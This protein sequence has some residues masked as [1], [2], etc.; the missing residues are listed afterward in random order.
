MGASQSSDAHEHASSPGKLL[1]FIVS[2]D[3]VEQTAHNNYPV[4]RDPEEMSHMLA[5]RF[6]TKCFSPLEL[7]HF[8]DNFQSLALNQ[9]DLQYWNEE[10]LSTFLGIPDGAGKKGSGIADGL[11]DSGPVIFRMVSYLGAFPFQNTLAPS[12]LTFDAMVKVIVLLTERYGKV[13]RRGRKDRIKLL[14]GSLADIGRRDVTVGQE[15]AAS[16][17]EEVQSFPDQDDDTNSHQAGFSVDKPSHDG[18]EEYD[19]DDD[20]ALAALESL[21]AIEVFKHDQRIDRTVY[22]ARISIR[23]FRQLLFLLIVLGP[24]Q[25]N[26]RTPNYFNHLDSESV[27]AVVACSN[28]ILTAFGVDVGNGGGIDYLTFSRVISQSFPYLFDPLTSLFEHLLFSKNLDL[29]R[30][31]EPN[32]RTSEEKEVGISTISASSSLTNIGLLRSGDFDSNILTPVLLSQLSFFLPTSGAIPNMF[33]NGTHLHPVFSSVA[34]GESLT[35][36]SHHV[37]TW[38]APSI[39][40]IRGAKHGNS[41]DDTEEAE[42]ITIGAY[43]PHPWK[44]SSSTSSSPHRASE[45]AS[46]LSK[47][48]YLFQLTPNHVVLQGSP[49]FAFLK[50]NLPVASFSN[51]FGIA[52]GCKIPPS[53][54]TSLGSDHLHPIPTGGGSLL[55]DSALENATFVTFDGLG[56]GEGVFLPPD[57]SPLPSSA[58]SSETKNT[59]I[60]IYNLEVWGVIHPP[61]SPISPS[62]IDPKGTSTITSTEP[63]DAIARQQSHWNFE[64]REAERRR[65]I[66]MKVGGG[67]SE[68]Q[69]GRALLEMAGIIGDTYTAR[70]R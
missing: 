45:Y 10:T 52:L 43:L 70:R 65:N 40:L 34:H 59:K 44:P 17:S 30:K 61:V 29:S 31:K 57:I 9:D 60:S 23:T 47:L 21:D 50:S 37:L 46:D 67:D 42:I 3:F 4:P 58:L 27:N 22:E 11:L 51:K 36:F 20:L 2:F 25:D 55:I 48:P 69:T 56:N 16:K 68:E 26:D 38:E 14:F 63:V 8:K 33:H 64:A 53:S 41:E 24:L 12:L 5:H 35:S 13:L 39:M 7:A 66:H 49:N 62:Q 19:D 28:R 6:A 15:S 18:D 1:G 54:R 32:S